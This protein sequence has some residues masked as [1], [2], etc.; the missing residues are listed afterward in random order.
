M[1]ASTD[2]DGSLALGSSS[3]AWPCAGAN[4]ASGFLGGATTVTGVVGSG[5][6]AVVHSTAD[7]RRLARACR[8]DFAAAER[9]ERCAGAGEPEPRDIVEIGEQPWADV[10]CIEP[11]APAG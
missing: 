8:T 7:A 2:G 9:L 3:S 4:T 10:A 5:A 6:V 11:A 1:S